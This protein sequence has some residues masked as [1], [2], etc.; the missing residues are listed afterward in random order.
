MEAPPLAR[1]TGPSAPPPTLLLV[2]LTAV[3]PMSIDLCLPSLPEMTRVFGAQVSQVQLILSVFI[4]GFAV[5]QPI[6]G[7]LSDRFGRRPVLLGGMAV[8]LAASL[9]CLAAPSIEAL[10]LGRFLQALGGCAGPVLA[11][12]IVRDLYPRNHAA[13]VL[14][15]MASAMALGPAIAPFLGGNLQA[16]F[17]WRAN[18]V[19]LVLLGAATLVAGW[20]LL[21]ETNRHRD[22][23]ALDP[24]TILD[25]Y[26]RLLGDRLFLGYSLTLS[27]AFGGLFAFIS[28]GAFVLIDVLGVTPRLFGFS[29]V[30]AALGFM[31]GSFTGSRLTQRVGLERL[32]RLGVGL[33]LAGGLVLAGLAL[34]GVQTV[35]AVM[36]PICVVFFSTGLVLPNGTAAALSPHPNIAGSASALVGCLQMATGAAAGWLVGHLHNGT[37]LAMAGVICAMQLAAAMVHWR[38]LRGA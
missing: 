19:V 34:G 3:A 37:T 36:A 33:G 7:P 21:A 35:V 28:G 14:S 25:N 5:A 20:S 23:R 24:A 1:P 12:A 6:Y 9:F 4:G 31:A 32:V 8:Y 2:A 29:F 13:R 10:I 30:P 16:W 26:R 11:R 15:T 27:F 38:L 22:P 18:F 17:G